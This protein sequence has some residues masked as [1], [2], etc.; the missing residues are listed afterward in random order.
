MNMAMMMVLMMLLLL[1]M[2]MMIKVEICLFFLKY[3]DDD[4]AADD[5]D[6]YTHE[7]G[8][9]F[10]SKT[11]NPLNSADTKNKNQTYHPYRPIILVGKAFVISNFRSE[12]SATAD[13]VNGCGLTTVGVYG[14]LHT[15]SNQ[16]T[17]HH[18]ATATEVHTHEAN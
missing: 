14:T 3:N 8:S 17:S 4:A 11:Q 13:D 9:N 5:N 10:P 6:D 18:Q 7:S 2:M 15:H 1:M 12:G 16:Q